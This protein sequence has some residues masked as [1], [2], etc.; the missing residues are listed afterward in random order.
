MAMP[1]LVKRGEEVRDF[2]LTNVEAH[3]SDI[4]SLVMKRFAITRQAAHKH[5]QRLVR[6][7]DL[8]R[9]GRTL[10]I[11]YKLA[12]K[13]EWQHT[14]EITPT[15]Q[16]SDVWDKDILPLMTS[17]SENALDN[18]RYCFTEMFNNA[19]DHSGGKDISVHLEKTA[20]NIEVLLRDDGVGIFKKIQSALNLADERHAVLELAKG[21][22]TTDPAKHTGEGIFFTSRVLDSF[23]ILSGG[24]FFTHSADSHEDW[25]LER[26]QSGPGTAVFMKMSN[27]SHRDLGAV[28]DAH[29][30]PESDYK[31]DMTTVPVKLAKYGSDELVSRSQAKR[32]M[33]RV[34]KF[35]SVVLDFANVKDVGQA[36]ADEIFRVFAREHPSTKISAVNTNEQIDKMISRARAGG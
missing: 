3:S 16:E 2:V 36:F 9:E 8:E 7:Q 24:V 27:K 31:F 12:V 15:L 4:A 23:D 21:K 19:I 14:Y 10:G 28:F 13:E 6:A 17:V 26:D 33:A 1:E 32:L 18:W 30:S 20:I 22:L 34:D 25:T 5:L 29:V 11:V 35:K